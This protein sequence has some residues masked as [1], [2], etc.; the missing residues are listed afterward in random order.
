MNRV[1]L[2]GNLTR[3]PEVSSTNSGINVCRFAIAVSRTYANAD[4]ERGVDF[5]N[6][7][8]WRALAD[9]CGK[10]L[11]KGSKVCVVGSLQN[12]SYEDADGKKHYV[13]DIVDSEVEF[14]STRN[15]GDGEYSDFGAEEKVSR[16]A[17][18]AP[19]LESVDD[20]NDL[21]F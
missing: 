10:F 8:A 9:N 19:V 7:T 3:D 6:I 1:I 20:D 2:I 18:K 15:S 16:P 13:T 14:L 5:F 12:R 4:G 11:K 21:P 17:K